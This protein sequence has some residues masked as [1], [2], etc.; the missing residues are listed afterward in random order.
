MK[1]KKKRLNDQI[2][3]NKVQVI[4]DEEGN[5]GEMKLSEA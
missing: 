2:R 3:A 5:L 4:H 1:E